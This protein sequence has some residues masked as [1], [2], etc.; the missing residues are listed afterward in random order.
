[1]WFYCLGNTKLHVS[2][3]DNEVGL[4]LTQ[5]EGKAIPV[6]GR[7][8]PYGCQTLR[9]AFSRQSAHRLQ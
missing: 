5:K 1:M 3:N 9:L 4:L 8:G 7:G 6:T 2:S